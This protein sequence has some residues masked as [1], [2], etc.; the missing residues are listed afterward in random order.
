MEACSS[1][2]IFT[3]VALT[4]DG[5]VWWPG[6]SNEVPETMNDWLRR[7][8]FKDSHDEKSSAHPNSRFC[9]PASQCP[10]IDD[11]WED[12]EGV[13]IEAII[14]GGR[15]AD[16]VPLVFESR[17]WE[18]GTYLGAM[19]NSEM[20]AAAAGTIGALRNDPFAMKPF[21]G[22]NMVFL[23]VVSNRMA[24]LVVTISVNIR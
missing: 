18:H 21:C 22:Y 20:T 6:I 13:P 16:T 23:T 17:S 9:C 4:S 10:I 3:N 7:E 24:I 2:T 12:P 5:D 1:N 19:M 15:R 14:F 11:K 8:W